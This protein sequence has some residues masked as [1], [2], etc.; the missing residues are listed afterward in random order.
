MSWEG[1]EEMGRGAI[2]ANYDNAKADGKLND[3]SWW[4]VG[5][6]ADGRHENGLAE[7]AHWGSHLFKIHTFQ[8]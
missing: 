1:H 3:V 5:Q 4:N 2:F 6:M 8:S 7:L